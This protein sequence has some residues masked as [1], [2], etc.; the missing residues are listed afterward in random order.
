MTP[1]NTDEIRA[2]SGKYRTIMRKQLRG[3]CVNNNNNYGKKNNDKKKE[4]NKF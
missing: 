2:I 4:G 3:T 1:R